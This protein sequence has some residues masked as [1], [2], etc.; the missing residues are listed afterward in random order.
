MKKIFSYI[1]LLALLV[2]AQSHIASA[3]TVKVVVDGIEETKGSIR[4]SMFN[5]EEGWLKEGIRA[6]TIEAKTPEIIWE[7]PGL[8]P[9]E[10]AISIVH[11]VDNNGELN[12]GAFGKPTEPYGFS[13]D[14][15]GMFGPAKWKNAKFA[16]K[17]GENE[18]RIRVY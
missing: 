18:I 3:A 13:N 7:V 2:L 11:D 14:A 17:E 15:R 10:Y 5:S 9:G 6:E 16:V 12:S 4:L 1:T 8:E